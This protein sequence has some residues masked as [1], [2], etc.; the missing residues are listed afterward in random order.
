[1]LFVLG[2]MRKKLSLDYILSTCK[3]FEYNVHI[4][5]LCNW[6]SMPYLGGL[7]I[8]PIFFWR[9]VLSWFF[10]RIL[11]FR[12]R[13]RNSPTRIRNLSLFLI[14][15]VFHKE[16]P[17]SAFDTRQCK[18]LLAKWI[19]IISMN[20]IMMPCIRHSDLSR[21]TG[22]IYKPDPDATFEEKPN[23]LSTLR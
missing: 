2:Y 10:I 14:F 13:F 18:V 5:Q 22:L 7:W 20:S 4:D 3:L 15:M 12:F 23:P 11:I 21:G 8:W 17:L 6:I 1:M 19:I 9:A 16:S